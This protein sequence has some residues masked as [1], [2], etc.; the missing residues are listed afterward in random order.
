MKAA[1]L[2]MEVRW[3]KLAGTKVVLEPGQTARVGR[4]PGEDLVVEHDGRMSRQHFELA[5][6]GSRAFLRDLGSVTG[7]MVGGK[8][9]EDEVEIGHATWVQ[10][11]DTHF[12]VYVEDKTG[13]PDDD[14]DDDGVAARLERARRAAAERA[15]FE[16]RSVA[17]REPLYALLD[18]ARDDRILELLR[19]HV[20]P[21]RSLYDGF[22]GETLEEVAP[23]LAGPMRADSNLLDRLVL[24]GW[25]KRWGMWCTSDEPFLEVRRHFRRFLMV[26]LEETGEKVYFRF[27]DPGVM[28]GFWEACDEGQKEELVGPARSWLLERSDGDITRWRSGADVH[29]RA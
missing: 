9:I 20:E 12:M 28:T 7:T 10:A 29:S 23:Y 1:R 24:E 4:M 3:G 6:D 19:E 8:T 22:E 26:E 11:G 15:L 18:A 17:S 25:G 13:S 16:L 14:L 2:I 27:Y 5:W 21:H